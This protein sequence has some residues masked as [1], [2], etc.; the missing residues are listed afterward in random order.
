MAMVKNILML[1]VLLAL[2]AGVILGLHYLGSQVDNQ[3]KYKHPI[4]R[5]GAR[6]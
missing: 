4:T 1:V 5:P 2:I 3:N 6:W